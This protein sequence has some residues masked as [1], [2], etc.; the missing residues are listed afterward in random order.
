MLLA[1]PAVLEAAIGRVVDERLHQGDGEA[2]DLPV[3]EQLISDASAVDDVFACVFAAVFPPPVTA[4]DC[5]ARGWPTAA[6]D[7]CCCATSCMLRRARGNP[8]QLDRFAERRDALDAAAAAQVHAAPS[9]PVHTV[10]HARIRARS[11]PLAAGAPIT[12]GAA[13]S[14]HSVQ[15]RLAA[16]LWRGF[17]FGRPGGGEGR[18]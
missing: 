14:R 2:I 4:E 16:R 10:P 12:T 3:V 18:A 1:D 17:C 15:Q 11:T 5:L 13:T 9:C 8:A 6:F 7:R